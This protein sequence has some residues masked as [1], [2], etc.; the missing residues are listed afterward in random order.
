MKI[1]AIIIQRISSERLVRKNLLPFAGKTLLEWALIRATTT[2]QIDDTILVTDSQEMAAVA[3]GYGVEVMIQPRDAPGF[4]TSGGGGYAK[5]YVLEKLGDRL[6]QYDAIVDAF[7]NCL[8]KPG[9]YDGMID[10][11]REKNA[12]FVLCMTRKNESF[13]VLDVGGNHYLQVPVIKNRRQMIPCSESIQDVD[14]AERIRG[15][16]S[17][18]IEAMTYFYELELWQRHSD[19]DYQD[20]FDVAEVLFKKYILNNGEAE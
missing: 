17:A 2:Q 4:G 18:E 19:V 8:M 14:M 3:S 12:A 6:K 20:E 13:Q 7:W 11:Y 15:A 10:M 1:L 5:N 9:D 16:S